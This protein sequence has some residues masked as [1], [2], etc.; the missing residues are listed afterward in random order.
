MLIVNQT[1]I[2]YLS[3]IKNRGLI[4][5]NLGNVV[6]SANALATI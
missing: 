2:F 4:L 6:N 5:L 3:E 1:P